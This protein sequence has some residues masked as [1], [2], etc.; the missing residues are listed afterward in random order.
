MIF[1]FFSRLQFANLL[2]VLA[3][4]FR[5]NIEVLSLILASIR[6][7]IISNFFNSY[8]G[9]YM[10]QAFCHSLV[11]SVISDQALKAWNLTDPEVRQRFRLIVVLVPI[12]SFPVYQA[13]QHDRGSFQFRLQALFDANRWMNM[14]LWGTVSLG[15]L[16]LALL[17]L[18]SLIF[19]F[20]EVIPI[21]IHAFQSKDVEQEGVKREPDVFIEAAARSIDI[22]VPDIFVLDDDELIIFSTT[23]KNPSVYVSDGLLNALTSEQLHAALAHE[24]AHIARSR[25]PVLL[26]VFILRIIMFFNPISLVEFRRAVRNEEKICDD[27]AV[28][29]TGQPRA[30]IEALERFFPPPPEPK[31]ETGKHSLLKPVALEDYSHRMQLQSRID[32]LASAGGNGKG[33][34]WAVFAA[35]VLAVVCINYFI[36]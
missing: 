23:G 27:V 30:L 4:P 3:N 33:G 35:T 9:M 12:F 11:A 13:V 6:R 24:L 19:L 5:Y 25:R 32:R 31:P 8:A 18:T 17:A 28:A 29:L 1:C 21:L 26:A 2:L 10:T 16:F 15:M 14:E 20:Q 22:A 7:M 36:V 34:G